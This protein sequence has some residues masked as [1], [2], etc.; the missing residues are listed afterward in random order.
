MGKWKRQP[1]ITPG[2]PSEIRQV[3]RELE[4]VEQE[5]AAEIARE[6]AL[7]EQELVPPLTPHV[8]GVIL[9]PP[10][11]EPIPVPPY[12]CPKKPFIYVANVEWSS[13]TGEPSGVLSIIDPEEGAVVKTVHVD[14]P[15][16]YMVYDPAGQRIFMTGESEDGIVT[17]FDVETDEVSATVVA[18]QYPLVVGVDPVRNVLYVPL[19]NFN[20]QPDLAVVDLSTLQVLAT[21]N[22]TGTEAA[23]QGAWVEPQTGTVYAIGPGYSGSFKIWKIDPDIY[24]VTQVNENVPMNG[25]SFAAADIPRGKAYVIGYSLADLPILVSVD[26]HTG[27]AEIIDLP[28][29][30]SIAVDERTGNIILIGVHAVYVIDPVTFAFRLLATIDSN[31]YYS[32]FTSNSIIYDNI[33]YTLTYEGIIYGNDL[34]TGAEVFKLDLDVDTNNYSTYELVVAPRCVEWNV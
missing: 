28:D 1:A 34:D 30:R 5:L 21:L 27:A 17:I 23:V 6:E 16:F 18:G 15:N 12:E 29:M 11:P 26:I 24:Q 22:I 20:N 2:L 25:W 32:Q 33:L 9:P 14:E 10:A 31:E 19:S 8:P 4:A 7:L 13:E 3:E